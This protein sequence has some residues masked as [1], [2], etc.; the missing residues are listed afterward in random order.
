MVNTV[1]AFLR[2]TKIS[3]VSLLSYRRDL[4]K[5]TERFSH[6]PEAAKREELTEYFSRQGESLS[7][8][9]LSRQVSVVR[10]Y[11]AYLLER[12]LVESN[13]MDGLRA[14][15]FV[16]KENETLDREE[17]ARLISLSVPGF[18]GARDRAMLMLLCEK[19]LRVT[20]LLELDLCDLRQ[21]CVLCGQGKRRR[22]LSVS[23]ATFDALTR[24]L[25]LRQLHAR[26]DGERQPLFITMRGMRM[27]RQGFWKNLK[28]RAIYSGIDKAVS[29]HTLRRSLALHLM[30]DGVAREEISDMLGNADPAS[31]R[32]YLTGKK[33]D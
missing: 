29:P 16:R 7:P 15:D 30:E 9:S 31:L 11:Y 8:S 26:R 23:A 18:C 10:S 1:E 13:P 3:A 24:Y 20:E 6:R 2:E 19:G 32:S 25:A 14:R 4:E 22:N 21:R 17:F 5:L 33:G 27:T 28:D 12:K